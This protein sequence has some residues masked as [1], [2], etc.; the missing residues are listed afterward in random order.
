MSARVAILGAGIG[1]EHL[2]GYLALAERFEV[3]YVC[4]LDLSRAAPLAARAGAKASADLAD[5]LADPAVDLIDICLPPLLHAEIAKRAL[6]AG[7]HVICEKPLA[8]SIAEA[9]SIAEAAGAARRHVFPVFQYRFGPAFAAYAALRRAGLLGAPRVATL[10]T[11]WSRGAEYYA[12]PWRGARAHELGGAVLSHAIHIHDL[13]TMTFGPIQEVS[14]MLDTLINPIETDDCGAIIFRTA[15][16]ALATSSI[17]LGAAENVSRL[18]L[19]FEHAT[20]ESGRAPYRPAEA[21]WSFRARDPA[22]QTE[23]D[24]AIAAAEAGLSGF[25]GFLTAVADALD[26]RPD[27]AVSLADGVASIELATAI[28]HANRTGARVRLPID[29]TLPLWPEENG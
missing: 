29:R 25:A 21:E 1:A 10:E 27:S 13:L 15:G 12:V 23:L 6:G 20:L 9:V 14:A 22:R 28:Y 7:K 5:A 4:D 17:T 24:A 8:G 18:R 26:G 19:V 2:E 16:G 11:H 3:A